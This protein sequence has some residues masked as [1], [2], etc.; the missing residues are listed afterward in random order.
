VN[1]GAEVP[2]IAYLLQGPALGYT[3]AWSLGL[4]LGPQALLARGAGGIPVLTRIL[5]S[6]AGRILTA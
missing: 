3:L 4:I 2:V 1:A 5:P 6:K